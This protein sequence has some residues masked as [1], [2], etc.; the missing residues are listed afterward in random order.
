[1]AKQNKPVQEGLGYLGEDLL[2][3][4]TVH[5]EK[6]IV[7]SCTV[8][9]SL[10]GD[11]EIIVSETGNVN[12]KIEGNVVVVAGKISGDML[13]H[14]RL[15]VN[16]TA[17]LNGEVHVPSGQLLIQEG[18]YMEGQCITSKDKLTTKQLAP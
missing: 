3:Q 7:V 16:S 4:G 1:M 13:V 18:A 12:G 2:I 8:E 11:Q 6:K 15:E 14:E 10:Y 5:T 17:N 9:G